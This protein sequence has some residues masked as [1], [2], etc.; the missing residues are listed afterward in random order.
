MLEHQGSPLLDENQVRHV[1]KLARLNLAQ[2]DVPLLSRQISSILNYVRQ[3]QEPN[4][5]GLEPMAH[6]LSQENRTVH[7]LRSNQYI[8][9]TA[10]G[11]CHHGYRNRQQ[12]DPAKSRHNVLS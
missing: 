11:Q 8:G 10:S 4:V 12:G 7:R 2:A 5:D 3:I 1:A 9:L 6:P